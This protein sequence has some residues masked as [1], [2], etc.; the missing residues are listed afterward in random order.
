M[1][2]VTEQGDKFRGIFG[3]GERANF[4]FFIK[5]GVYSLWSKDIPTPIDKGKFPAANMYGVH[6]YF[7]YKHKAGSWVGILYNLAAA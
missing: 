1:H 6:P 4:D 7:M 5:D 3:L 2:V